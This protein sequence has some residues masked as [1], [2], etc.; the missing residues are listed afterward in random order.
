MTFL[1]GQEKPSLED[2][3]EHHGVKGMQWGVRKKEDTSARTSP[4]KAMVPPAVQKQREAEAK[5]YES[6]AKEYQ[7][8]IDILKTEPRGSRYQQNAINEQVKALEHHRDIAT[9]NAANRREGRMTEQQ[10]TALKGAAVAVGILA[11][12][13]AYTTLQSG[14]ARSALT[15]GQEF[16]T[17]NDFA[18]KTKASLARKMDIENIRRD[19]VRHINPA[20][21][22]FGTKMNCRRCTFAYELRRRGYDVAATRTT[23]GAG[24]TQE[25]LFNALR[26]AT[27]AA[28]VTKSHATFAVGPSGVAEATAFSKIM[29]KGSVFGEH[30]ITQSANEGHLG[31]SIFRA[32]SHNP[33]GARGELGVQWKVGGGHS[34]AWEIVGGKPV[35]FDCQSGKHFTNPHDLFR[36]GPGLAAAGYTRLDNVQMNDQFLRRWIK[37]A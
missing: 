34:V 24:Q 8:R 11:A 9:K 27:E 37:N 2:L 10:K 20:Y 32:L 13:A 22:E 17:R 7:K 6:K 12:Y 30:R 36:D 19:V 31:E 14:Q 18:W 15:R 21:G 26:A 16:L 25:G 1:M 3:L 35:V 4:K 29:S 23:K 28:D 5:K 33:E